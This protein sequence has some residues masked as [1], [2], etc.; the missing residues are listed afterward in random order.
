[1]TQPIALDPQPRLPGLILAGGRSSRMGTDKAHL[2]LGDRSVLG[3]V[4][5]RL[6]SQVQ[7]LL[8]NAPAD[9]AETFGLRLIS[10]TMVG[11]AGPLAGILAGM[12]GVAA[13]GA[14]H[15]LTAPCDSPFLPLDLASRLRQ[16]QEDAGQIVVAA[17]QDRMHP[18][19]GIW[20][21]SLADDLE[22]WLDNPDNRRINAY[23]RRHRVVTVDFPLVETPAGPLDPFLNL[24]TPE[25]LEDA[26]RFLGTLA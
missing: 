22:A 4:V 17:S 15:L 10:D 13:E 2:A 8:L 26:Q 23:L 20:P 18:V 7:P 21:V 16:A 14:S 11:Q 3:H 5:H 24:N 1:M 6:A 12:R 25:D 9:F 19:F